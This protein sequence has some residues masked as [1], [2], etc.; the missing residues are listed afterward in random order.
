[1]VFLGILLAAAAITVGIA[2]IA[3]NSGPA[4]LSIFDQHIPGVT[5]ESQVFLAGV[6]LAILFMAGLTVAT[7][8][9][10]R[11]MRVRRQLRDLRDEHDES[12]NTLEMEKRQLQ[13]ELARARGAAADTPQTTH[14]IPVAPRTATRRDPISPFFDQSA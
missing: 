6:V 12:V 14:D 4:T 11:S 13:R 9:F 3:D 2:V 5:N 10:G 1:M 8:G 7:L